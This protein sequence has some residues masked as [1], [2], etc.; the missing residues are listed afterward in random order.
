MAGSEKICEYSGNYR[1]YEMYKCKR[2]HIQVLSEYRKEFR[3]KKAVLHVFEH[4]LKEV[5]KWGG[6]SDADLTCVNTNPTDE[7]WDNNE[8]FRFIKR[9]PWGKKE[10]YGVFFDNI[11]EYKEALKKYKT[12]LLMEYAYILEVPDVP[13]EVDGLYTN[14][15][16]DLT[17]VKR[18]LRRLVGQKNLTIVYHDCTLYE[19]YEAIRD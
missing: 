8:Y 9:T 13:G 7:N 1:A 16:T 15:S 5:Y 6:S 11:K 10:A 18:R 19:F 3:G 12:R 2:N 14:F 17:A 4:G